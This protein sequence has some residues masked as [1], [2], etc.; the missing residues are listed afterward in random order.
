MLVFHE[1]LHHGGRSQAWHYAGTLLG[2]RHHS[3]SSSGGG[4]A[5]NGGGRIG[6]AR[7]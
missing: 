7:R 3:S 2:L 4:G 5:L 1:V 6:R